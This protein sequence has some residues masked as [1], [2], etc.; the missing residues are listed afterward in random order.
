MILLIARACY[1]IENHLASTYRASCSLFVDRLTLRMKMKGM[2][3]GPDDDTMPRTTL[4]SACTHVKYDLLRYANAG[5]AQQLHSIK[6]SRHLIAT[7]MND[8]VG[9]CSCP[10]NAL[11]CS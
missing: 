1:D 5:V 11:V 10:S 8:D 3:Q 9:Q 2:Y 7:K 6:K 4:H